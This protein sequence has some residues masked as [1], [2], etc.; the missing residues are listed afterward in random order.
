MQGQPR[1]RTVV[2][3]SDEKEVNKEDLATHVWYECYHG[4]ECPGNIHRVPSS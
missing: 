4:T 2:Y 3:S 1:L